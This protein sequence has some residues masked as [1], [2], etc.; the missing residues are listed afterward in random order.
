MEGLQVFLLAG[1]IFGI[2]LGFAIV[3]P[4]TFR[5]ILFIVGGIIFGAFF[6]DVNLAD[7]SGYGLMAILMALVGVCVVAFPH[8]IK[9]EEKAQQEAIE[10]RTTPREDTKSVLERI[11]KSPPAEK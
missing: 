2:G 4:D 6:R 3:N 9:E 11:F 8:I 5:N 7:P 1:V 10:R